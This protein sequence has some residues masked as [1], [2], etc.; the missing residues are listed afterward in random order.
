MYYVRVGEMGMGMRGRMRVMRG[1][2]CDDGE[3][4]EE[5]RRN[6]HK[7]EFNK[8]ATV[9]AELDT[10]PTTKNDM[11]LVSRSFVLIAKYLNALSNQMAAMGDTHRNS[12]WQGERKTD[13]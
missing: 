9:T 8:C 6:E 1:G 3:K 12:R 10:R 5:K 7:G 13:T 2:M 11:E 4:E